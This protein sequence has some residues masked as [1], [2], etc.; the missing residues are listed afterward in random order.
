MTDALKMNHPH[1]MCEDD[2]QALHRLEQIF[3][4]AA[5]NTN[6]MQNT[7]KTILYELV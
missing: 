7:T 1:N 2:I 6:E 5:D 4:R 3:K